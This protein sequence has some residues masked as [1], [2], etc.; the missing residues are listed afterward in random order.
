MEQV[1]LVVAG[2]RSFLSAAAGEIA[3]CEGNE[4]VAYR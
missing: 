4:S 1:N 2:W 3:K